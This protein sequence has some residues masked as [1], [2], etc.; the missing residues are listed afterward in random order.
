M[1][2]QAYKKG[3]IK[4][5][6][7]RL[8]APSKPKAIRSKLALSQ[9]AFASQS[10]SDWVHSGVVGGAQDRDKE[11][12]LAHLTGPCI[13]HRHSGTAVIDKALLTG[14]VRLPQGA[15]LWAAPVP[16]A[17]TAL[18]VAVTPVRVALGI[19]FLQQPFGY[20]RTVQFRMHC[21]PVRNL[22]APAAAGIGAGARTVGP[23]GC[24]PGP[25][26]AASPVAG[27]GPG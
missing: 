3:K 18:G 14:L 10:G 7:T 20:M 16:V 26:G 13:N 22:L 11:L 24:H 12:G 21:R 6:A 4:L 9:S 2:I 25:R 17:V 23:T 1:K 19:L 8:S 5:K 15:P 27:P